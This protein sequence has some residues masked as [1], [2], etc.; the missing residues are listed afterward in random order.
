VSQRGAAPAPADEG[1][2]AARLQR[3]LARD[4]RPQAAAQAA[5]LC[6]KLRRS[7]GLAARGELLVLL[8]ALARPKAGQ[9]RVEP[10]LAAPEPAGFPASAPKVRQLVQRNLH[11]EAERPLCRDVLFVCQGFDGKFVK[12]SPDGEAFEIDPQYAASAQAQA[13][14]RKLCEAGWLYRQLSRFCELD[15]GGPRAFP[16]AAAGAGAPA[17]GTVAQ[18]FQA[19][20]RKE[21]HS[22]SRVLA[23]LQ[24]QLAENDENEQGVTLRRLALW[25][26]EPMQTLKILTILV[27]KGRGFQGGAL[28]GELWKYAEH[29]DPFVHLTIQRVLAQVCR[30]L[31]AMLYTWLFT[32]ELEDLFGEFFVEARP[33]VPAAEL[34]SRGYGLREENVPPFVSHEVAGLILRTG[35][36][37]NF[38]RKCC[39]DASWEYVARNASAE[40]LRDPAAIEAVVRRAAGEVD[41]RLMEALFQNFRFMAHSRA[42]KRYLLLGQGDFIEYL[43]V[44]VGPHL[45]QKASGLSIYKLNSGFDAAVRASGAQYDDADVL[46]RLGAHMMPH[47]D[48]ETGWDVFSLRYHVD[49]PLSTVFTADALSK[50]LRIFNFLWRLKRVEHALSATWQAMKPSAPAIHDLMKAIPGDAA[51][52]LSFELKRCHVL[53]NQMSHFC[54]ALQ[55]YMMF[56]VLEDGWGAFVK[57]IQASVRDL[58]GLIETHEDYLDTVLEKALLGP[59]SQPLI[60]QLNGIFELILQFKGFSHRFQE[61]LH[62]AANRRRLQLMQARVAEGEGRWG[63]KGA[64]A[65]MAGDGLPKD[66]AAAVRKELDLINVK[67]TSMVEGFVSL[68]PLVS[69]LD[70][71]NLLFQL[72]KGG[73]GGSSGAGAASEGSLTPMMMNTTLSP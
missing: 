28:A 59:Q 16:A 32:G 67:Y 68:F 35:K 46:G 47:T 11:S 2:E 73:R 25:L 50:Y 29:G 53:R 18:A 9:A 44:Q 41:A 24:A 60:R 66:F 33:G 6:Q 65:A 71:R 12:F 69:H 26:S 72:D 49:V 43:M 36:S 8:Q 38:L 70:L 7:P 61:M 23:L 45:G 64:A 42:L 21:L 19:A 62:Q 1:A 55:Y 58:D 56:E 39:G 27:D 34:W 51:R 10:V 20:M 40:Q 13:L 14:V 48:Q 4:R 22:Y 52:G 5:G 63:P 37:I 54:T 15:L 3:A 30:P 57:E 31:M 17:A